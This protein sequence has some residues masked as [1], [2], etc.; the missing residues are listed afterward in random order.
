MFQMYLLNVSSILGVCCKLLSWS[1]K[2]R[3]GCCIYMHVANIYFKCFIG[4]IVSVSSAVAYVGYGFQMF[5][6]AF[7]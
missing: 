6:Q 2:S 3:Y 1:C 5:L 7:S 4:T